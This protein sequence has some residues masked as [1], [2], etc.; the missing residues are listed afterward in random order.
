[1]HTTDELSVHPVDVVVGHHFTSTHPTSHFTTDLV[2]AR[3]LG[4]RHVTVTHETVTVRRAGAPTEHRHLRPGELPELFAELGVRLPQP[5]QGR[6]V[7]RWAGT[8]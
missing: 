8:A 2:L 6:L 1:M 4:E 3:H 5:E 7:Q